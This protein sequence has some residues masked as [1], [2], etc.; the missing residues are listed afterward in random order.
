MRETNAKEATKMKRTGYLIQST[1]SNCGVTEV[2]ADYNDAIKLAERYVSHVDSDCERVTVTTPNG[3]QIDFE[4]ND[5][6][7]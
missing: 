1:W 7:D 4:R 5:Y 6:N 3:E 2:V